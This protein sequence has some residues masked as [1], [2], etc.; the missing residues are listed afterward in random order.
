MRSLESARE[1][2]RE[3]QL[4]KTLPELKEA[5][6]LESDTSLATTGLRSACW[7]AFLLFESVDVAEWQRT[8]AASRSAY[9]ALR[10]HFFRYIDHPDSLAA[11]LDPLNQDA[12]VW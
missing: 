7:K 11:D 6:R 4:Y 8:L 5:I 3:L 9:N 2:W 12:E 10:S 1:S